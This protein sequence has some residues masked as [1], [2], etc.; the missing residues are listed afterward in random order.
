VYGTYG[1][2]LYGSLGS[3][4]TTEHKRL[5]QGGRCT[6]SRPLIATLTASTTL[7][8]PTVNLSLWD[9]WFSHGA[10]EH[11][12][13]LGCEAA[14]ISKVSLDL[15]FDPEDGVNTF[16]RIVRKLP[17]DVSSQIEENIHSTV[18]NA[19]RY[20]TSHK[21]NRESETIPTA[22]SPTSELMKQYLSKIL[23]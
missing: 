17:P 2:V 1:S 8:Y 5:P 14:Y 9:S 20:G 6:P 13:L 18:R 19:M 15:L 7:A 11:C 22:N 21:T 12:Y 4:L 3:R 23:N 16:P 10:C